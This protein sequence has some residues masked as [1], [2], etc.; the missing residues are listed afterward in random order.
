MEL[1]FCSGRKKEMKT[2]SIAAV[3]DELLNGQRVDTNSSWLQGR[4]LGLGFQTRQ[5]VLVPDEVELIAA[6]LHQISSI[7]DVVIVTGGLGPTEDD[8]TRHA[9]A[10]ILGE[11]LEFREDLWQVIEEY[12][13]RQGLPAALTNQVQ[14][15]L[16]RGTRA[17]PNSRGTA[18]GIAAEKEGKRYFCLPGVP[19]EMMVMFDD[20]VAPELAAGGADEVVVMSKVRCYGVAEAVI[21]EKLGDLMRRGRNPLINSTVEEGDILLHIIAWAKDKTEAEKMIAADRELLCRLLGDAV[22]GFD[23]QT[24]PEVVGGL[25]KEKGFKLA[26]AESCTGGMLAKMIT[27]IA[28]SSEYFLGGWVTYSNEAKIRDLGVPAGLIREYGAV[29]EPVA[30][31]MAEGAGRK[32]GAQA[33]VG[34]SGIAGPG[35]GTPQKPVGM[36]C[37]GLYFDG[38]TE[39]RTFRFSP[40][41]R[42]WVRRRACLTALNWL[43]LLLLKV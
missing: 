27:D 18:F 3:G 20:Y 5:V 19:R 16:P 42:D 30:A 6:A 11:P 12:F 37:I 36:V 39:V 2:V 13:R 24:L 29:S 15:R 32:S 35:G 14:A 7:S 38:K 9:L 28:G 25:L 31:A 21:A 8:L 41:G 17:I 43:R 26:A 4:L 22:Y 34:I 23:E 10:Q 33:A 40:V 1:G